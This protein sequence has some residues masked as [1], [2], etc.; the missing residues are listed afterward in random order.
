VQF[1][2]LYKFADE[3]NVTIVGGTLISFPK[4]HNCSE[5]FCPGNDRTVGASGGW[6]QVCIIIFI[7]RG[8]AAKIYS[9]QLGRRPWPLVGED[10]VGCGQSCKYYAIFRDLANIYSEQLQFQVVTPDGELRTADACQN[11]DLFYALRGGT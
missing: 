11:T 1:E 4:S 5:N 8:P 7:E 2:Q 10:G 6:L 9:M 3:H